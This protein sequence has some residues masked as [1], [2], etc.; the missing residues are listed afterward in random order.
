ME[1]LAQLLVLKFKLHVLDLDFVD[2]AHQ[3]QIFEIRQIN[4]LA[5]DDL[6]GI[7]AQL[8]D[9]T[10]VCVIVNKNHEIIYLQG[11]TGKYLETALSLK[12]RLGLPSD[13]FLAIYTEPHLLEKTGLP[14]VQTALE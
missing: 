13:E 11:R 14:M 1:S 6:F 9:H 5:G 2:Q 3:V 10:P 4:M 12:S 7:L 8:K